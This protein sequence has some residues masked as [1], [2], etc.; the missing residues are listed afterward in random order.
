MHE[1]SSTNTVCHFIW[2]CNIAGE[3]AMALQVMP[4]VRI[5]D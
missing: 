1:E 5:Q 2:P 3:I 4:E